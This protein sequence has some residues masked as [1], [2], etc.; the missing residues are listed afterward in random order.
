MIQWCYN[1]G[2]LD[3]A[4][5]FVV[6][7]PKEERLRLDAER[8]YGELEAGARAAKAR[9]D[10][11]YAFDYPRL[12]MLVKLAMPKIPEDQVTFFLAAASF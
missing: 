9:G 8:I 12:S 7:P 6:W 2:M 1:H 11:V 4:A 10:A 3:D 5:A